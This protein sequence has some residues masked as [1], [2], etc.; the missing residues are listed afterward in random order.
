MRIKER[1]L[2]LKKLMYAF[3]KESAFLHKIKSYGQQHTKSISIL[4]ALSFL[5]AVISLQI[6]N[7]YLSIFLREDLLIALITLLAICIPT[8][9]LMVNRLKE[10]KK[11]FDGEFDPNPVIL[12]VKFIATLLFINITVTVMMLIFISKDV[13]SIFNFLADMVLFYILFSS[14][15]GMYDLCISLVDT[16]NIS[17][18]E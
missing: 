16:Y 18:D 14:L 1:R 13:G 3:L 6:Q 12:E 17:V 4:I 15:Y 11:E 9:I 8:I 2:K 5:Y 10:L 7:N